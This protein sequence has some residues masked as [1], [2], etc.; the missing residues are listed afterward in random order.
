ML[1]P[2]RQCITMAAAISC[3]EPSRSKTLS[4]LCEC[5]FYNLKPSPFPSNNAA[6]ECLTSLKLSSTKAASNPKTT[7]FS[8]CH[9]ML[10]IVISG[11]GG[12][13]QS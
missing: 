9:V 12:T 13:K 5:I 7:F 4:L 1:T 10:T 2:A 6:A 8:A 11:E 3:A